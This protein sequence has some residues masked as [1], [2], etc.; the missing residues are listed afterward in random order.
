[1]Y[2][3]NKNE[4]GLGRYWRFWGRITAFIVSV[5]LSGNLNAHHVE[6]N[7]NAY[8][9]AAVQS[10][11]N[12]M[13]GQAQVHVN[14][15]TRTPSN[16]NMGYNPHPYY[17]I[18]GGSD[19][20][21]ARNFFE[22]YGDM[23]ALDETGTE[24]LPGGAALRPN[25]VRM[26]QAYQGVPIFGAFAIVSTNP[27]SGSLRS[28]N[29]VIAPDVPQDLSVEAQIDEQAA[30]ESAV[31]YMVRVHGLE[32]ADLLT[33]PGPMTI[34]NPALG[35]QEG[36][37]YFYAY[38]MIVVDGN[39]RSELVLVDADSGHAI[40]SISMTHDVAPDPQRLII[41]SNERL[42]YLV[43]E[44]WFRITGE[45]PYP[46]NF[47]GVDI[48]FDE[49]V[50]SYPTGVPEYDSILLGTRITYDLFYNTLGLIGAQN[51]PNSLEKQGFLMNERD[52]GFTNICPNA[53]A[54]AV[55]ELNPDI[56][57]IDRSRRVIAACR[58]LSQI[59]VIGHEW[60]HDYTSALTSIFGLAWDSLTA[61]QYEAQSGA[62]NESY[63]DIF[64]MIVQHEARGEP[65]ARVSD[66]QCSTNSTPLDWHTYEPAYKWKY[67]EA[68]AAGILVA[69][70]E[71][72]NGNNIVERSMPARINEDM[73]FDG[74]LYGAEL[75]IPNDGI[76]DTDD[77]CE[78]L[79]PGSLAGKV[80]LV[81]SDNCPA[82]VKML[83]ARDAGAIGVLL[84]TPDLDDIDRL[85][86]GGFFADEI[87]DIPGMMI[88]R[89]EA[90]PILKALAKGPV[91]VDFTL[92]PEIEARYTEDF[93]DWLVG[94]DD[95]PIVGGLGGAIRDMWDPTC[96]GHPG[97]VSE[98]VCLDRD[99]D[100]GGVHVN[101][102]VTNHMAA[103][104]MQGGTYNGKTVSSIGRDK[105]AL[106]YARALADYT[107]ALTDFFEHGLGLQAACQDLLFENNPVLDIRYGTPVGN[108]TAN[109]CTQV[110]LAIDAVE[111]FLDPVPN[112]AQE[113]LLADNPP[114]L[115][116]DGSSLTQLFSE[117]FESGEGDWT[118]FASPHDSN[119][120]PLDHNEWK[121]LPDGSLPDNKDGSPRGGQAMFTTD[122]DINFPWSCFF[123]EPNEQVSTRSILYSPVI[124][125]SGKSEEP[126]RLAF[127][128]WMASETF[129]DG[130]YVSY[131]VGDGSSWSTWMQVPQDAWVFNGYN[132]GYNQPANDSVGLYRTSTGGMP[133]FSGFDGATWTGSWGQSQALLPAPGENASQVQFAYAFEQDGCYGFSGWGWYVDDVA[134]YQCEG[135][136]LSPSQQAMVEREA[137]KVERALKKE[138]KTW[139]S[140]GPSKPPHDKRSLELV[141]RGERFLFEGTTDVWAHGDYAYIGTYV[142][143]CSTPS[144]IAI[145]I[146]GPGSLQKRED[147]LTLPGELEAAALTESGVLVYDVSDKA[148]PK[149]VNII[150]G[151]PGSRQN[152]VKVMTM[153]NSGQDIL[154][155]S[156]EV[157]A[158][159]WVGGFNIYNVDDPLN[160][161]LLDIPVVWDPNFHNWDYYLRE[162]VPRDRQ[163]FVPP[164]TA[165]RGGLDVG[166]HN[167]YLFSQGS[168]DFVA[169]MS[170]SI[171]GHLQFFDITDPSNPR[172]AGI[173][174]TELTCPVGDVCRWSDS[175]PNQ[176]LY[177]E[178]D[179]LALEDYFFGWFNAGFGRSSKI[180]YV[181]DFY[182]SDDGMRAWVADWDSGMALIDLS[183]LTSSTAV[184]FSVSTPPDPMPGPGFI[185]ANI[186]LAIPD[187]SDPAVEVNSHSVWLSEDLTVAV[188]GDEDFAIRRPG[189]ELRATDLVTLRVPDMPPE[190]LQIPLFKATYHLTRDL[191]AAPDL[192][193]MATITYS[194]EPAGYATID[195]GSSLEGNSYAFFEV[196]GT[197]P[198]LEEAP[199]NGILQG[200][201]AFAGT[202]CDGDPV[203]NDVNGK[204]AVV[205]GTLADRRCRGEIVMANMAAA[206]AIAVLAAQQDPG[207][208]GG[209]RIWD[210]SDEANPVLKSEFNTQCGAE[211]WTE[212]CNPDQIFSVHNMIIED[213]VAY[214]SWYGEG[215][216]MLDISDPENPY[217][218][219]R[220]KG[221]SQA[222]QEQNGGI[223]DNRGLQDVWGVYKIPGEPYVY[224]SD[225]NG[226][227]YVLKVSGMNKGGR[228]NENSGK[229]K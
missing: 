221:T 198:Q 25:Q 200:E 211:P 124:D 121:L 126:L 138:A 11:V 220:F 132:L 59:D 5:T 123:P 98:Y 178:D 89:Q 169:V 199:Y 101:S 129:Y 24:M 55:Y 136:Q 40:S 158:S 109:D 229:K 146:E 212:G 18:T 153:P 49:A 76:S 39:G 84:Y 179:E 108:L 175:D 163:T 190:A 117:D 111:L 19:E 171:F 107:G 88:P 184:D 90:N 120:V 157:C 30:R 67:T 172:L 62:L 43:L 29:S 77:L 58:G 206:G 161:V 23:Y 65:D 27:D 112:C 10:F 96:N 191:Q 201:L 188:E 166:V 226:G 2:T 141:G 14:R 93:D 85:Y 45:V 210:Y 216:L 209:I 26:Y 219:A 144:N 177:F 152:D 57:D 228:D 140:A 131:R 218:I 196:Q 165:F 9:E 142:E 69:R 147:V 15:A 189:D 63:S 180:R 139:V 103:L 162:V 110:D 79:G 21:I 94:V 151:A 156:N 194:V 183:G 202:G 148:K 7:F 87:T 22:K 168:K 197:H 150:P 134:V 192:G 35:K 71:F 53:F 159:F 81:R 195:P 75:V 143:R 17:A 106:I 64:G 203:L 224:A 61:L 16:I 60:A 97:K 48:V 185:P 82:S 34:Y 113:T 167:L 37:R 83:Y 73:G 193:H 28:V 122:F 118:K 91:E 116:S 68:P 31:A 99:R 170:E 215:V 52:D 36:G 95:G 54:T 187:T 66:G 80:A 154:V 186:S 125:I 105:V 173:W 12:A 225:R 222:F 207:G 56:Q 145:N 149:L 181:H 8:N 41:E 104:L 102:G 128:H 130:G 38:Q 44:N 208:W 47:S 205:L 86:R 46:I 32:A 115:C 135:D 50:D 70:G 33:I 74:R 127:D 137:K 217:E 20:E 4:C 174:G 72:D 1:M 164:D 223:E 160:P 42:V 3:A 213:D 78:P 176:I 92:H 182:V 133:L 204:I 100:Y 227:L 114:A 119:W 51:N 13:G 6:Q 214:I 155:S